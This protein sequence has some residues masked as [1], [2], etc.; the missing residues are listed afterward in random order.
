MDGQDGY[1]IKALALTSPWHN[2]GRR[3]ANL[4]RVVT[5]YL[6]VAHEKRPSVMTS[7]DFQP[8]RQKLEQ[9]PKTPRTG[10]EGR[11]VRRREARERQLTASP[12]FLSFFLSFFEAITY[13]LCPGT[14]FRAVV[15]SSLPL[16]LLAAPF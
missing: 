6:V 10:K 5:T 15:F 16:S 14:C 12:F 13:L 8:A 4:G 2:I 3:Q 11:G 9:T 1:G 7:R